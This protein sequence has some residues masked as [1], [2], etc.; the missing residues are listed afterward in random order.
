MGYLT[1]KL[2]VVVKSAAGHL[3]SVLKVRLQQERLTI[4]LC[5]LFSIILIFLSI[6]W[7][8]SSA[9]NDGWAEKKADFYLTNTSTGYRHITS[10]C[11]MHTNLMFLMTNFFSCFK[12]HPV[13]V[14]V[15]KH[16]SNC[17]GHWIWPSMTRIVMWHLEQ[18]RILWTM[19]QRWTLLLSK[20]YFSK[21]YR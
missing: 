12:R 11:Y 6:L 18:N 3:G 8:H 1:S 4:G 13:S 21:F 7:K 15:C 19:W 14:T 2:I 16:C 17:N 9:L 20:R 10:E 5:L